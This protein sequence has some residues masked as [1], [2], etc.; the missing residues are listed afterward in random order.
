MV[1][2]FGQHPGESIVDAALQEHVSMVVMGTRGLGTIRRTILGS[3]SD[4]VLHHAHCPV[5]VCQ[6]Q[7]PA[8][9][10]HPHSPS[11]TA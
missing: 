11:A 1:V 4:Y 2:K 9:P 3:V 6:H 10:P 8:H 5:A 7:H